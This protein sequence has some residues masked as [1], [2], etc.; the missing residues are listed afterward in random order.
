[1][2]AMIK[3]D[4]ATEKLALEIHASYLKTIKNPDAP[5]GKTWADLPARYRDSTRI[6]VQS[7]EF[8]LACLG[9]TTADA[10]ANPKRLRESVECQMEALAEAEHKRWIT[11]KRLLG[12]TYAEQR[13]EVSKKHPC[14]VPYAQLAE[15]DKEKDR[16]MWREILRHVEGGGLALF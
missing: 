8:K 9:F 3:P 7:V 2:L 16:V 13:N 14:M 6:Q 1:M 15:Q 4:S 12:W 10:I 11:E 5:A